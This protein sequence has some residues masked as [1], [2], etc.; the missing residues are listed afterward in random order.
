ML[1]CKIE[2]GFSWPKDRI[3]SEISRKDSAAENPAA[4]TETAKPTTG[5]TFQ[6]NS[7]KPY[8]HVV[9]WSINNDIKFS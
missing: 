9:T 5:A 2:L 6:I 3:I 1:N 8:V 4:P 7:T